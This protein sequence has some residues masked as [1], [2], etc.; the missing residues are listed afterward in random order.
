MKFL[1][2]PML[3]SLNLSAQDMPYLDTAFACTDPAD[4]ERY[5]RDF[6]I[7]VPSFGGME[8]CNSQV[9]T[10]KLLNDL[11]ILEKGRFSADGSNKFIRG[12]VAANNY[13]NWMKGETRGVERGQDVPYATAYNSGGYFTM[14]DG[15]AKRSCL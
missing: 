6:N 15:W 10:K 12:F 1:I 14:Q 9:D 11:E 5:I 3:F 7:D 2:I 13:Y 4:A 8:L